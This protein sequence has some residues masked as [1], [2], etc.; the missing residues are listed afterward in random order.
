MYCVFIMACSFSYI[1][2]GEK[3][4]IE[5][6][7]SQTGESLQDFLLDP[8]NEDSAQFE[9]EID[10]EVPELEEDSDE[11]FQDSEIDD[12]TVPPVE[13][14]QIAPEE[15][16]AATSSAVPSAPVPEGGSAETTTPNGDKQQERGD[17]DVSIV[18]KWSFLFYFSYFK[19]NEFCIC[20]YI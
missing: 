7:F 8:D 4:G 2:S 11:G 19:L 17:P 12:L 6:L 1:F 18:L 5:Y 14:S 10:A 16:P 20:L 15:P 13:V 9:P 3:L